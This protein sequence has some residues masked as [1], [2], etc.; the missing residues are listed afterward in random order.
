[1]SGVA[2][3]I[4]VGDTLTTSACRTAVGFLMDH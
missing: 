1:V 3:A 4:Q 2:H